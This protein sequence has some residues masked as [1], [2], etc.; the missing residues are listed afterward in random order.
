MSTTKPIIKSQYKNE[1]LHVI[2][3]VARKGDVLPDHKI[4][5]PAV[6]CIRE[7]GVN[8]YE[9][10]KQLELS[11]NEF[12]LIPKDIVH[13]LSFSEAAVLELITFTNAKLEFIKS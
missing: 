10:N 5:I 12:K 4:S 13:S 11:K 7:G 9:S 3:I 1:D 2:E 8:Y 6:L